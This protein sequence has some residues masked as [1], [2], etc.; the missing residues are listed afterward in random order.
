MTTS[1][2]Q[3]FASAG[4]ILH[5]DYNVTNTGNVTLTGIGVKSTVPNK[6]PV[7]CVNTTLSPG[8]S[9]ICGESYTA[10]QTDVKAGGVTV[11]ATATGMPPTGPA[12]TSAPSTVQVPVVAGP[13]LALLKVGSPRT[14]V[15]AGQA[16][17]YTYLVNNTG[18]T[19][20]TNLVLTDPQPGLV[21]PQ[22]QTTT[23]A[24]NEAT[25]CRARYITTGADVSA[26]QVTNTATVTGRTPYTA[27]VTSKPATWTIPVGPPVVGPAISITT[28]SPEPSFA[29]AG[30]LLRFDYTVINTGSVP[31][32]GITVKSTVPNTLPIFCLART[33]VPGASTLCEET[34]DTT[35]G[36]VNAGGVTSTATATGTPPTGPAI[37]SAPS[38]V[39]VPVVTGPALSLAK[40]ARVRS[41]VAAGQD[42]IYVYLVNN[43]GNT[44]LHNVTVK[45]PHPGLYGPFCN[46]STL[47][48]N[49]YA[50]CYARY[51]TTAADVGAGKITNTATVTGRLP[52]G[53]TITSSPATWTVPVAP[54]PGPAISVTATSPDA[55]FAAAGT[56]LH[57]SY[58][59]VNMG[60]VALTGITVKSE[61]PNPVPVSCPVTTLAPGA[62]TLC[63]ESYTTTQ[64][65]VNR[66]EVFA[67]ATAT[68]TPPAGPAV[69]SAL[70]AWQVPLIVGPGL[71]VTK[72]SSPRTF[73][74]AGQA[75]TYTY[76]VS[77]T[78]HAALADLTVTDPQPGLEGPVCNASTLRPGQTT[79]C[80]AR[81]VTTAADVSAGKITNT[82]TATGLLQAGSTITSA[83]ASLTVALAPPSVTPPGRRVTFVPV[84]YPFPVVR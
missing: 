68:G 44:V 24:P 12:V 27:T 66:G 52:T 55:S 50:V 39:Q 61:L 18:N 72:T 71:A 81:Y 47:G 30:A 53:G 7:F 43:P 31:L 11:T 34:Y 37:T 64:A 22:C 56:V 57:F 51:I 29:S 49:D 60:T 59:V 62:T 19:A 75:V 15:A 80:V 38:T 8:A 28:T 45:D 79:S 14:F 65:D 41:F 10:T 2:E 77:N 46:Q 6:T 63:G 42:V 1:P 74:A 17:L 3:S 58:N 35:Q 84:P 67:T 16:L 83:P 32:T 76:L 21:G 13:A 20:L 54:I 9:T 78:G 26:G 69:T 48:P 40:V 73:S 4:A 36:D 70:S 23:L 82:A 5:F 33:L 25:V